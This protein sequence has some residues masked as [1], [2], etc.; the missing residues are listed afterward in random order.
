MRIYLDSSSLCRLYHQEAGS[1][2]LKQFINK[3]SVT[4]IYL[5]YISK[6]EFESTVWKKV[7]TKE[8]ESVIAEQ[9]VEIFRADYGCAFV[10]VFTN[11]TGIAL[12]RL[13]IKRPINGGNV[14]RLT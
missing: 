10:N 2:E 13:L 11:K 6:L 9:L 4:R 5:S 1:E 3:Q 12:I 8:L 7:R 14:G